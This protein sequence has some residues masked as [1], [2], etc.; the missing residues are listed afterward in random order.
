MKSIRTIL[1]AAALA[2]GAALQSSAQGVGLDARLWQAGLALKTDE[3]DLD[4]GDSP[5]FVGALTYRDAGWDLVGRVGYGQG[6]SEGDIEV[7]RLELG[8]SLSKKRDIVSYGLGGRWIGNDFEGGESVDYYGPELLLGLAIPVAGT[9][10]SFDVRGSAGVFLWSAGDEDG[11]SPG[12]SAD[13]GLSYAFEQAHIG[14]G[15]RFQKIQ[16]DGAFGGEELAGPYLE[17]GFLW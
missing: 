2:L 3:A 12:Y 17:L 11:T 6:W 16:E 1:F 15:Y 14:A 9:R 7:D 10:L 8:A 13:A 5:M 4:L